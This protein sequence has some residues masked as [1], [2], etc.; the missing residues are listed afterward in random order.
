MQGLSHA[1]AKKAHVSIGFK[2][3]KNSTLAAFR[4]LTADEV[5]DLPEVAAAFLQVPFGLSQE[6]F[7]LGPHSKMDMTPTLRR[8]S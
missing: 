1:A 5:E 8:E 3:P 4:R 2:D 7:E 6:S